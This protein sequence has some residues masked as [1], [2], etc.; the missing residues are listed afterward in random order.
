MQPA[1]H[2]KRTIDFNK[3][4]KSL[5][6]VL[7]LVAVSEYHNLD[8]KLKTFDRLQGT[9]GEFFKC[10]DV[11]GMDHPFIQPRS[12]A[13]TAVLAITS[14]A[15]L[16]GGINNMV[17]TKAVGLVR[18]EGGRLLVLGD[19][20]VPYAQESNIPFTH[21]PGVVDARRFAQA[22]EVRDYL[23]QRVLAG[24]FGGIKVVYPRAHSFTVHRVETETF[25]PFSLPEGTE[26]EKRSADKSE[27]QAEI[28][29]ESNP[30]E[31]VEYL[32]YIIFGQRLFEIFGYSR[33][34]EQ[35]ARY[36]H[37][38]ESCNKIGE[39]NKK[40]LLQYF[41]RRHEVIDSNMRELFA[42]RAIYAK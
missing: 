40:L 39:M 17:I 5:L 12:G 38:E 16:L 37:L 23:T 10:I 13:P 31:V 28:I 36:L 19:R 15:G 32:V 33:V 4:F 22:C 9:L 7:K 11:T 8:R 21:F 14:D 18:E 3:G 1:I 26:I 41:R 2:I 24:E 27:T 42:S 30:N 29:F 20:G 35:A 25:I 6:E 34:C